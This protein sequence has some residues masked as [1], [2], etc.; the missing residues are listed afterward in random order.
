MVRLIIVI[1][2]TTIFSI[3]ASAQFWKRKV[4]QVDE[5]GKKLTVDN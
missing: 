5:D 2:L 4:N 1:V 3:P